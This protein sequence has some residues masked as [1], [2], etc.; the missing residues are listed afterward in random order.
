MVR[1]KPKLKDELE[2]Y[3][4]LKLHTTVFH[5]RLG[6]RYRVSFRFNKNDSKRNRLRCVH[7]RIYW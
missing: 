7:S 6:P 5:S 4:L 2:P 3:E 1:K